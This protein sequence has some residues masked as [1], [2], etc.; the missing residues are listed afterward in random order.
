MSAK[1]FTYSTLA[2]GKAYQIKVDYEGNIVASSGIGNFVET[3]SAAPG[4]PT[5][6]YIKGNYNGI[7]AKTQTGGVTYLIAT[8]SIVTG[9]PGATGSGF[10]VISALSNKLLVHG[11]TNSGGITYTAKLIYASG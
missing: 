10:E 8:P 1:E 4:N 5:L 6:S 11:F 9:Q 3:A 2:Y 7:A